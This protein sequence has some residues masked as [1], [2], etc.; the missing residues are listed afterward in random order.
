MSEVLTKP[1]RHD[2]IVTITDPAGRAIGLLGSGR[3]KRFQPVMAEPALGD[4]YL[5]FA[6][7]DNREAEDERASRWTQL[8][9]LHT[10]AL[11]AGTPPPAE[12]RAGQ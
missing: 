8:R 3:G 9:A 11:A 1:Y 4:R 5:V 7:D 12:P 2:W 10:S 6:L